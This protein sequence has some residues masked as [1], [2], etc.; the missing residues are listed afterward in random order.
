VAAP[1][2][3]EEKIAAIILGDPDVT[4]I[5]KMR[6]IQEGRFYHVDAYIELRAGLTLA[7]ADDIKFRVRD[8]LLVDSDI[9]DVTLGIIEDN[10]IR[11]W[12]PTP[13]KE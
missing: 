1:L 11:D 4:D 10:G 12:N 6:I 8:K 7:V 9:A 5:N 13:E 3:V 2:A